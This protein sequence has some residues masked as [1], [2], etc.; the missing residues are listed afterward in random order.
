MRPV[1]KLTTKSLNLLRASKL[2]L[3][4]GSDKSTGIIFVNSADAEPV[5]SDRIEPD[6]VSEIMRW[7]DFWDV[8]RDQYHHS[9]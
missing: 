7:D 4:Q 8:V 1:A 6:D 5:G 9:D 3:A 2:L